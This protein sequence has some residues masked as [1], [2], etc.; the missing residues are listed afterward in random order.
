MEF[1]QLTNQWA[2]ENNKREVLKHLETNK[3]GNIPKFMESL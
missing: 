3:N 1:K 2:K